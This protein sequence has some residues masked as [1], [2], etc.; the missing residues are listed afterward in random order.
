MAFCGQDPLLLP[1]LLG[2]S[3]ERFMAWG[4]QCGQPQRICQARLLTCGL[5]LPWFWWNHSWTSSAN[6][7][8]CYIVQ[9]SQVDSPLQSAPSSCESSAAS[10]RIL[11]GVFPCL[12]N[13]QTVYIQH[14]K[15]P[16]TCTL[17]QSICHDCLPHGWEPHSTTS[18]SD[19][20][21]HQKL[22]YAP[23]CIV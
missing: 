12:P 23:Y 2:L 15:V 6:V 5:L 16:G 14:R 3:C 17:R 8:K 13:Q 11:G 4:Y 20:S 22:F 9:T 19:K 21:R 18:L 1:P 10:W 7:T